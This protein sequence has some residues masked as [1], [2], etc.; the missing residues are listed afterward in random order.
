LQKIARETAK[1]SKRSAPPKTIKKRQKR[2][3][4]DGKYT[5][6]H[7]SKDVFLPK[8]F[9]PKMFFTNFAAVN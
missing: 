1:K 6:K 4:K 2:L 7:L 8:S 9:F 5:K 3:Y